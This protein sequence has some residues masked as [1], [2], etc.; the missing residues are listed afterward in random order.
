M[1]CLRILIASRHKHS[2]KQIDDLLEKLKEDGWD[3]TNSILLQERLTW[4][5]SSDKT[6]DDIT[7]KAI[8]E[9]LIKNHDIIAGVFPPVCLVTKPENLKVYISIAG[10]PKGNIQ[11]LRWESLT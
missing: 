1:G 10:G 5:A 11:H 6:R 7:N 8:W 9:N 3:F 4:K 2:Q